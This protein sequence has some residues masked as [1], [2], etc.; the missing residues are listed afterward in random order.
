M[1][2]FGLSQDDIRLISG[3]LF[4]FKSVLLVF[5]ILFGF[6]FLALM[7]KS[8]RIFFSNTDP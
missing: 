2:T 3:G 1:S 4:L 5:S 7:I 6:Q 8:F